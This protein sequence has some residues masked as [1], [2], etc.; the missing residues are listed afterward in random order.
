LGNIAGHF[1]FAVARDGE[2]AKKKRAV[3]G[4]HILNPIAIT[5]WMNANGPFIESQTIKKPPGFWARR[6]RYV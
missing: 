6:F 2:R 5:S 4:K 3:T 1:E